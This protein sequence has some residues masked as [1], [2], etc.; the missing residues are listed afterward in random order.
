MKN[1]ELNF[2]LNEILNELKSDICKEYYAYKISASNG[3]DKEIF[4]RR[5]CSE[6]YKP[7]NITEKPIKKAI[8]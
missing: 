4:L 6:M 7:K 3:F 2:L 5:I 1:N 8:T